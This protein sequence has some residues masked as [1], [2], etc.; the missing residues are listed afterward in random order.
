METTF[1]GS[2]WEFRSPDDLGFDTEKFASIETWLRETAGDKRYQVGIA[3]NGYLV[4]QWRQGV[5]ADAKFSQASAAKSY[6]SSLLGIMVANGKLSSPDEKVVDYYP[7]MM[8]VGEQ[9]GPKPGRYA[10][11]KDRAIT[12]RQLICNVSGY[13]KPGEEPGKVFHYQTY[14]MNIFTHAMAKIY[15]YYDVNDPENSP[16]CCRAIEEQLRNP[17]NGTWTHSHSNFKLWPNARLK[18]ILC[19]IRS[20]SQTHLDVPKPRPCH[21][22]KPRLM[23]QR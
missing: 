19:R 4:A 13:M 20:R 15:G 6:Y 9:E 21:H 18:R 14:G 7:E 10:F 16:G 17:I 12:F 3:R 2:K 5:E 22:S 8:D 1:P 11:E 23:G